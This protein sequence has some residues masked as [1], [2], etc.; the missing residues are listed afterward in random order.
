MLLAS[1]DTAHHQPNVPVPVQILTT[2]LFTGFAISVSIVAIVSFGLIGVALAALLGWQWMRSMAPRP[3]SRPSV[4][5]M[6]ILEP[7]GNAHFDAYRDDVLAT[8]ERDRADFEA[9]LNRLRAAR[10]KSEFDT[11]LAERAWETGARNPRPSV[12]QD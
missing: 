2:I 10:D 3:A 6:P 1:S 9:Y 11:F 7:T 5:T 8:L 12:T 4:E